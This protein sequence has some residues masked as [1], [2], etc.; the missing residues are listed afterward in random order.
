MLA[1]NHD[2]QWTPP[3]GRNFEQTQ[4][5]L[6]L[7]RTPDAGKSPWKSRLFG[8]GKATC[9]PFP[10]ATG[11]G[12]A[13]FFFP[14]LKAMFGV[15]SNPAIRQQS[16]QASSVAR[17]D[18]RNPTQHIGQVR[19]HVHAVSPGALHQRVERRRRLA[20]MFTSEKQVVLA[21]DGD[22]PQKALN[23][24]VVYWNPPIAG[25]PDEGI[26]TIQH[27]VDRLG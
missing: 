7:S 19:P 1:P 2:S 16:F 4:R 13:G 21:T 8:S 22:G 23:N 17:G 10:T 15:S 3:T 14:L 18:G 12:L 20:A 27:V 6:I 9:R 26:P 24:I 5:A 25:I 11:L